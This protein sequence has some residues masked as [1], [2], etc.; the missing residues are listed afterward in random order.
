[1]WCRGLLLFSSVSWFTQKFISD[2]AVFVLKGMLNQPTWFTPKV[3]NGFSWDF[4]VCY[5]TG[6]ILDDFWLIFFWISKIKVGKHCNN[7]ANCLWA[8]LFRCYDY[9]LY[10]STFYLLF[11]YLLTMQHHN[12]QWLPCS[13]MSWLIAT[14]WNGLPLSIRLSPTTDTFHLWFCCERW[15]WAPYVIYYYYYGRPM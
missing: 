6:N 2:I 7:T 15:L 1:M 11:T 10:K 12:I 8:L 9:A 3:L 14:M 4:G 5:G 13:G